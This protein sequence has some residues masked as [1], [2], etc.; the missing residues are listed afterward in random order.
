VHLAAV[1][2]V[3]VI[4]MAPEQLE[5]TR[6]DLALAGLA[7]DCY[8]LFYLLPNVRTAHEEKTLPRFIRALLITSPIACYTLILIGGLML[9]NDT[10][11]AMGMTAIGTVWLQLLSIRQAW[12][13]VLAVGSRGEDG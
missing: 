10:H 12:A 4:V 13:A 6:V 8:L 3:S 5:S 7:G 9:A 1:L 11:L 2:V